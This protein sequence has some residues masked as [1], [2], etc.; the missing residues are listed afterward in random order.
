[1]PDLPMPADG[2]PATAAAV[3]T[4]GRA[5]QALSTYPDPG[6][7]AGFLAGLPADLAGSFSERQLF[8]VQQAF[9]PW[10]GKERRRGWTMRIPL[11]WGSYVMS[12]RR[13]R[14]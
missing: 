13:V 10:D 14:S 5:P 6:F 7:V 9:G 2:A 4:P 3:P 8:A 12:I 1:M 11:P